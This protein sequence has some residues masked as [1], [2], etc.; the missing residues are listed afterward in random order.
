[1]GYTKFHLFLTQTVF[2]PTSLWHI[3]NISYLRIQDNWSWIAASLTLAC[4]VPNF[5]RMCDRI[6]LVR[7]C[8]GCCDWLWFELSCSADLRSHRFGLVV[9]AACNRALVVFAWIS[10]NLIHRGRLLYIE[11]NIYI[12]CGF[13]FFTAPV[14]LYTLYSFGNI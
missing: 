13:L 7:M 6:F 5:C 2:E 1:M 8:S 3:P 4:Q 14:L 11:A 9:C 10:R 12:V